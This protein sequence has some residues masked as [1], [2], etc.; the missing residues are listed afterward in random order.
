MLNLAKTFQKLSIVTLYDMN[1][2][3]IHWRY[4]P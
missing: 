4:T 3:L 2:C 1:Y